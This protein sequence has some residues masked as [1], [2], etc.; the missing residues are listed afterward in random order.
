[1][2][3]LIVRN[4]APQKLHHY[5]HDDCISSYVAHQYQPKPERQLILQ[6]QVPTKA[7]GIQNPHYSEEGQYAN[8]HWNRCILAEAQ[9]MWLHVI[10]EADCWSQELRGA[11]HQNHC[12]CWF[13]Q[14][15]AQPG[16]VCVL[17]QEQNMTPCAIYYVMAQVYAELECQAAHGGH[18]Q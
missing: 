10:K 14:H 2:T 16:P 17:C 11:Y 13:L 7:W 12:H 5:Y 6:Q 9:A 3:C 4:V 18:G 1:M 15:T 8:E